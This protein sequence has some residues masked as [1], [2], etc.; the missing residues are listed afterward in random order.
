MAIKMYRKT[1]IMRCKTSG[2]WQIP[3]NFSRE[4]QSKEERIVRLWLS[5]FQPS[6]HLKNVITLTLHI[7]KN[8]R[9]SQTY[10]FKCFAE[11][12]SMLKHINV[13]PRVYTAAEYTHKNAYVQESY[14]T[15]ESTNK[16]E[17]MDCDTAHRSK[18]RWS[19]TPDS[20]ERYMYY[21]AACAR[22]Y[23]LLLLCRLP[24]H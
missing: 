21:S 15:I 5:E 23:E 11:T 4:W 3:A 1:S 8:N 10:S 17:I 14:R 12:V 18:K 2:F 7:E 22:A 6:H 16:T 20:V 19:Q 9:K 13:V 24:T